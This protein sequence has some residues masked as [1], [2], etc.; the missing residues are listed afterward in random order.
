MKVAPIPPMSFGDE[1]V[2]ETTAADSVLS[3]IPS[4]VEGAERDIALLIEA[5]PDGR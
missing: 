2:P 3:L 4:A 1:W 5:M